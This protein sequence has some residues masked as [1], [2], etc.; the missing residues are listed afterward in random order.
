MSGV[1]VIYFAPG[2]HVEA[3]YTRDG[4]SVKVAGDDGEAVARFII[5]DQ[6]AWTG[7]FFEAPP[8]DGGEAHR[9]KG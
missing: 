7:P 5:I 2:Y 4:I 6:P 8:L 3:S 9:K 1:R